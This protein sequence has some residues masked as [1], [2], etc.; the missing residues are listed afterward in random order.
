MDD[1]GLSCQ[2]LELGTVLCAGGLGFLLLIATNSNGALV[3]GDQGFKLD[4]G[5]AGCVD[6]YKLHRSCGPVRVIE[7]KMAL[8]ARG[9]TPELLFCEITA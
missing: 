4:I 6:F 3:F 2:P 8:V 5:C 7:N 1:D 9:D